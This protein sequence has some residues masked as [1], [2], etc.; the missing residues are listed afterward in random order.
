MVS[1]G[2]DRRLVRRVDVAAIPVLWRVAP[3]DEKRRLR[4]RPKA[5]SGLLLDL[6]VSGLQV[7]APVA[8]DLFRG[9]VVHLALDDVH[10]WGRIRRIA[11]V[12]GT[13]F[14]N[15]GLEVSTDATELTEWIYRRVGG[16][17]GISSPDWH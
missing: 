14:A 10:G 5:Q 15:Y 1:E 2:Y 12:P 7:R 17:S 6:S 13:R 4:R 3:P 8:D 11:P 16:A 9:S